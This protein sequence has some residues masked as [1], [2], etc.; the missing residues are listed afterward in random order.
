MNSS[1]LSPNSRSDHIIIGWYH[2][3]PRRGCWLCQHEICRR[4]INAREDGSTCGFQNDAPSLLTSLAAITAEAKGDFPSASSLQMSLARSLSWRP[5]S[6]TLQK[7][8][9]LFVASLSPSLS[10]SLSLI[11][12]CT[13]AITRGCCCMPII[14]PR[15]TSQIF[16]HKK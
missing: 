12:D 1:H 9:F 6:S 13:A 15:F 8:H 3:R 10:L 14:S 4:R 11:Y 5:V 16:T 7:G 2:H